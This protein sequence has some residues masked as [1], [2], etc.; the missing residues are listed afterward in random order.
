MFIDGFSWVVILTALAFCIYSEYYDK[1]QFMECNVLNDQKEDLGFNHYVTFGA[2]HPLDVPP[3]L[4]VLCA[5]EEEAH[6]LKKIIRDI[7]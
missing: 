4:A 7:T 6:K 3:E 2:G 1:E 5:N